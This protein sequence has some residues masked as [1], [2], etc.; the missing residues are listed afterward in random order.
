[1]SRQT[2]AFVP[3]RRILLLGAAAT[4]F[5]GA[6]MAQGSPTPAVRLFKVVSPRDEIFVGLTAQELAA[7]QGS[8]P[9]EA[10]AKKIAAEGQMTVWQYSVRRG[11]GGT[12]VMAP[13][14]K[15]S[16]MA[17]GIVRIEPYQ[18][19]HPVIAPGA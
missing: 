18:P 2:S 3:A 13:L 16:L 4:A 11:D 6:A 5:A 8:S 1:M 12:L 17:A 19:A 9:A 10:M 15:V 7:L 14:A